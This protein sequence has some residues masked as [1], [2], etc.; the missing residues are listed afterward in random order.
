MYSENVFI[1][2]NADFYFILAFIFLSNS[3]CHL[4]TCTFQIWWFVMGKFILLVLAFLILPLSYAQG[5]D[6]MFLIY[7]WGIPCN[8]S[9]YIKTTVLILPVK[10]WQNNRFPL[11]F[12]W[13]CLRK[14]AWVSVLF[15]A[16]AVADSFARQA[17]ALVCTYLICKDVSDCTSLLSWGMD[18]DGVSTC[19]KLNL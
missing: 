11:A 16:G 9:Q 3:P 19:P 14:R 2:Q 17:P 15:V 12:P 10:L 1:R 4:C 7:E 18:K 5:K 13:L 8:A 6:Y